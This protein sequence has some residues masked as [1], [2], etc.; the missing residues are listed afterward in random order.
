MSL[1]H[2]TGFWGFCTGTCKERRYKTR[3]VRSG[4][5]G[6]LA[7]HKKT[8]TIKRE[9]PVRHEPVRRQPEQGSEQ[10]QK[11]TAF[12]AK[13]APK[14]APA[15]LLVGRCHIAMRCSHDPSFAKRPLHDCRFRRL[16]IDQPC[17]MARCLGGGRRVAQVEGY[18]IAGGKGCPG[19][20]P[21][22]A[23]EKAFSDGCGARLRPGD[24]P[25]V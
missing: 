16:C 21:V 1:H 10:K 17:P 5:T 4:G 19:T 8:H 15:R 13:I 23:V 7:Y 18:A 24:P 22:G 11:Q 2:H 3:T 12:T 6:T 25:Q 20:D 9:I 14:T